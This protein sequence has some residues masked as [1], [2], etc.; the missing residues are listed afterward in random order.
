MKYEI[1]SLKKELR[2][3]EIALDELKMEQLKYAINLMLKKKPRKS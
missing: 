1:N 3:E 2:N